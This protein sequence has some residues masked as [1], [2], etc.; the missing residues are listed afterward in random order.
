MLLIRMFCKIIF[1]LPNR[2]RRIVFSKSDFQALFLISFF[3]VHVLVK[4]AK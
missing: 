3:S 1:A 2:P 4:P